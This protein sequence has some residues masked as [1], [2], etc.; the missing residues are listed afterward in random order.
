MRLGFL[1]VQKFANKE[2][3]DNTDNYHGLNNR[4]LSYILL[5]RLAKEDIILY[6][7]YLPSLHIPT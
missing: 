7:K 4:P 6:F 2:Y 3:N 5:S 1:F